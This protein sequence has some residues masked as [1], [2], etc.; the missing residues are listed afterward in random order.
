[1][2]TTSSPEASDEQTVGRY[3]DRGDNCVVCD[4]RLEPTRYICT[5]CS[6]A[7]DFDYK[8]GFQK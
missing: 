7:F 6:L 5:V 8:I 4:S 1:M 3:P 2:S